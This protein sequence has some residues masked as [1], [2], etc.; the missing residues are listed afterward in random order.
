MAIGNRQIGWSQES[1]LLWSISSQIQRLISVVSKS[2]APKYKVYTALLTQIGGDGIQSY[3]GGESLTIGTTYKITGIDDG[4]FTA[5][6]APN[7]DINTQFVATGTTPNWGT[8]G[9]N[10]LEYNT[11]APVA[12]VL[13]NTIGNIWF[14]Y[15]SVGNY[16]VI[17]DNLFIDGKTTFLLSPNGYIESTEDIHSIGISWIPS[18][19]DTLSISTYYNYEPAD[20][21]LNYGGYAF[22]EIR[23]YN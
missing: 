11:G 2:L 16:N 17:S 13:E 22:I 6:G 7:N 10:V 14:I 21:E 5:V 3:Y 20:D 8:F 1:N 12:T 19:E 9:E 18:L 4:D 23:V 15:N